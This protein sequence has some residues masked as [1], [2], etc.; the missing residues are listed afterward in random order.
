MPEI[1]LEHVNLTV[2]DPKAVAERLSNWFGW[3]I[4]WNGPARDGGTTYHVGSEHSYLALYT[5]QGA[6]RSRPETEHAGYLNHV[7]VEVEDLEA[8]EARVR[9]SGLE[10]HSHG[11]YEPGRRFYVTDEDGIEFEIV[12]Y[13]PVL[14][15]Q[16]VE[17]TA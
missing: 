10:T 14:T 15:G 13:A 4:R 7:G 16:A 1:R 9:A 12:S 8:V 11:D 6:V 2:R 3:K 5:P 17:V